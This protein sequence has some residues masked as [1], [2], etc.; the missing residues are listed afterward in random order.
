M[1]LLSLLLLL[2]RALCAQHCRISHRLNVHCIVSVLSVSV[3]SVTDTALCHITLLL[4]LAFISMRGNALLRN[5]SSLSRAVVVDRIV[6]TAAL[7]SSIQITRIGNKCRRATSFVNT[8]TDTAI[9]IATA[10]ATLL[11]LVCADGLHTVDAFVT[12][13]TDIAG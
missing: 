5:A 8:A 4:T 7:S 10:T 11:L 13:H 12:R 9:A 3:L 1:L 2:C 6:V